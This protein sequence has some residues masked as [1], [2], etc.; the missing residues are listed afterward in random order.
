MK[1][2]WAFA[3]YRYRD[4]LFPTPLWEKALAALEAQLPE[5]Q[6]EMEYLRVLHLAAAALQYE[7][8][9]AIELRTILSG[10]KQERPD[11]RKTWGARRS[12]SSIQSGAQEDGGREV[13]R[14]ALQLGLRGGRHSGIGG[15]GAAGARWDS[16]GVGASGCLA[17]RSRGSPYL[18]LAILVSLEVTGPGQWDHKIKPNRRCPADM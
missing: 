1:K 8:E 5:R 2:P 6:A 12:S 18:L 9:A 16:G 14:N 13:R 3:R 11:P 4:S 17:T 7:V 10:I 15:S